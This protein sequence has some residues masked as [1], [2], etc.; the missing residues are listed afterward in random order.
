MNGRVPVQAEVG[1]GPGQSM[2]PV[3]E[4]VEQRRSRLVAGRDQYLVA[5]HHRVGSVDRLE[6]AAS[7]GKAE[8][9]P[10]VRGINAQQPPG[11]RTTFAS[12]KDKNTSLPS[13]RGWNGGRIAGAPPVSGP[14]HQ[15][16]AALVQTDH[17]G[18]PRRPQVDN[19]QVALHQ[20][21]RGHA[22]EI[23]GH[24]ELF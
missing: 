12:G 13:D 15:F 20:G 2:G 10:P 21:G 3:G 23:L 5:D 4:E 22:K 24:P 1:R 9:D 8:V 18:P 11:G 19:Q 17:R 7:P 6:A 16:A 14:P